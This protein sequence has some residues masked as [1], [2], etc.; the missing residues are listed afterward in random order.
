MVGQIHHVMLPGYGLNDLQTDLQNLVPL[1]LGHSAAPR[2]RA[3][4]QVVPF[5]MDL[6]SAPWRVAC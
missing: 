4:A 2:I 6:A 5:E 3:V 1:R